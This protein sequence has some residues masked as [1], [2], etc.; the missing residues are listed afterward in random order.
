[1]LF[2]CIDIVRARD[3][4]DDL[5]GARAGCEDEPVSPRT[6]RKQVVAAP[7]D[8]VI[9]AVAAIEFVG[10]AG[11]RRGLLP[12]VAIEPVVAVAALQRVGAAPGAVLHHI[13]VADQYVVARA[14][15]Q[16][17][18]R[19]EE[20]T[21]E[22]Q[23]LMRISYAVFCLKKKK[24]KNQN[25]IKN[26]KI[27]SNQYQVQHKINSKKIYYNVDKIIIDLHDTTL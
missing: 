27:V 18:A 22:L 12:T 3:E 17:V 13:T 23:S 21:S 19:S 11:P 5:V 9:G 1:M 14:A 24:T 15:S 7:A 8:Q 26:E 25:T 16:P 6:A 20:H 10:A 2:R 4:V